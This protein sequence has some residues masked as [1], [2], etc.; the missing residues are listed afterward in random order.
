M[1]ELTGKPDYT[2]YVEYMEGLGWRRNQIVIGNEN[3]RIVTLASSPVATTTA[4]IDIRVPAGQKMSICG[5]QQVPRGADAQ[6][7]HAFR[8]RLA[9]T[10]DV[11]VNQMTRIRI[12]KE[13]T[14]ENLVPLARCFYQDVSMVKQIVAA[15]NMW[16]DRSEWYRFTQGVEFNGEEHFF[17]YVVAETPTG[18][19]NLPDVA[20]DST[21]IKFA[22]EC[23]FWSA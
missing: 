16:K 6:T 10:S 5:Q 7:A 14:V 9:G 19:P 13:S 18:G 15:G 20:I 11:E 21:H 2:Q 22:L 12:T 23:D 4:V 8:V 3:T 17:V 1:V